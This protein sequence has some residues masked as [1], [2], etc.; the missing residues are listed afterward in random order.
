MKKLL[1]VVF[2]MFM[3]VP[4]ALNADAKTLVPEN[5]ESGGYGGPAFKF[6]TIDGQFSFLMGGGGAWLINHKISIGGM[7][8]GLATDLKS[9]GSDLDMSYFGFNGG[10]VFFPDSIV[11]FITHATIGWG[12]VQLRRTPHE[13]DNFFVIEPNVDAEI[14]VLTWV[15]LCAGVSYRFATGVNGITG[16]NN[17]DLSGLAG[18]IF[19][20]F[21]WF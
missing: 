18:T 1:I 2:A 5:F 6:T 19:I 13:S 7:G 12:E 16:I 21:G 3:A 20:K 11:H 17:S 15:R 9:G 14:N 8:F 10:Y 4:F